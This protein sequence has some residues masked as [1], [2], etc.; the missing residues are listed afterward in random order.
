MR[1]NAFAANYIKRHGVL[2][3]RAS[4]PTTLTLCA[5]LKATRL[6]SYG[7]ECSLGSGGNRIGLGAGESRQREDHAKADRA[8]LDGCALI[9]ATDQFRRRE[10]ANLIASAAQGPSRLKFLASP[11]RS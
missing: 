1:G 9:K 10:A 8:Q 11:V 5:R 7:A 3:L 2:L 4:R 6:W